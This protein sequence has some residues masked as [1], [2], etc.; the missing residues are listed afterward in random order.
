MPAAAITLSKASRISSIFSRFSTREVRFAMTCVVLARTSETILSLLI[1]RV[2]PEEVK[3]AIASA[4][5][6]CGA[7][8]QAPATS[9]IETSTP[10]ALKKSSQMFGNSV[11]IRIPFMSA[12]SRTADASGTA[13]TRRAPPNLRSKIGSTSAR[14][15]AIMSRPVIPMSATPLATY[16]GISIGRTKR[17][18]MFGSTV[19][20]ISWREAVI[21]TWM[22][23]FAIKSLIGSAMRPLFGIARRTLVMLEGL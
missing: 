22:P 5:P 2:V 20:A 19:F 10:A 7:A 14:R 16:S 1:S 11:A 6:S 15:S 9:T 8:S 4:T 21:F 17:I 3:S 12:T 13:K 23:A 18:S